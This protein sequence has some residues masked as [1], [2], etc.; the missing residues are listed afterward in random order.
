M[1]RIQCSEGTL[2][3]TE[4]SARHAIVA[5]AH[6]YNTVVPVFH[7]GVQLGEDAGAFILSLVF[8]FPLTRQFL[9]LGN[10]SRRHLFVQ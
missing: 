2:Q 5:G 7:M 9:G 10:L 6:R 1:R 3:L 4:P 8:R